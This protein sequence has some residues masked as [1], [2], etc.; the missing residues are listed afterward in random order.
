[1]AYWPRFTTQCIFLK[2]KTEMYTLGIEVNK[3]L[4]LT[5][6]VKLTDYLF[7]C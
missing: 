7:T 6:T 1:M 3:Y 4:L 2:K 5:T